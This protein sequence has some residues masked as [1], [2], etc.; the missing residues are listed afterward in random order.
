MRFLCKAVD[1]LSYG[2]STDRKSI[3]AFICTADVLPAYWHTAELMTN[4]KYVRKF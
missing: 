4:E 2:K 3:D 1:M